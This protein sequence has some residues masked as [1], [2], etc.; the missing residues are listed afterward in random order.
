MQIELY[1]STQ[2]KRTVDKTLTSVGTVEGAQFSTV[3]CKQ[4]ILLINQTQLPNFN[5]VYVASTGR[6]Y[7]VDTIEYTHKGL[8]VTCTVDVLMTYKEQLKQLQA[9]LIYSTDNNYYSGNDT[10]YDIRPTVTKYEYPL[11]PLKSTG[12]IV[13]ITI[14]G[15]V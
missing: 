15:S 11:Q 5:Y 3:G 13:V 6:Y 2:D 8:E 9:T 1:N 4:I 7:F 10:E 12:S 14:K